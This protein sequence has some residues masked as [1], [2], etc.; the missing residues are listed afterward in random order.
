[1]S[2]CL[3]AIPAVLLCSLLMAAEKDVP[4]PKDLPAYGPNVPFTPPPV[5]QAKLENGLTLWLAP[6][7]TFPKATFELVVKGGYAADPQDR[8]GIA[9]L[10][11]SA[12]LEGTKTLS[13]K[14]IAEAIQDCGGDLNADA[15]A[16]AISIRT[17]VL[18][19]KAVAA[20]GLLSDIAQNAAFPE[21]EVAIVK[22]NAASQ[23]E[24]DEAEPGFLG[25]RALRRAIFGGHPYAVI[26]PTK[27]TIQQTTAAELKREFARRFRP[28]H[29]ILVA[30]GD[31][32]PKQLRAVIE[33]AFGVWR[34][35]GEGI[36]ATSPPVASITK[37]VVY[38]PRPN[39]VQTAF[40]IGALAPNLPAPEHEAAELAN[41]IYGGMFGSRLTR[42]IREDKGYT[43]SPYSYVSSFSTAGLLVTGADVRN[44]VTG[45]SF[46]EI[47]Y[48]LNRLA[49]TTPETEELERAKRFS[50]GSMTIFLQAQ[51]PLARTL[52]EYWV[53]GLTPADLSREGEKL[54][55]TSAAEVHAAAEKYFPMSRMTIV[56][57]GD[58]TVIRRQLAPFG[59]ELTKSQ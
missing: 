21:D 37:T 14:Q 19:E 52:A 32:D 1:M 11:A 27:E 47:S 33:K 43:Y 10:V 46:N 3:H 48:E 16:D 8:P 51:S 31:F 30:I 57:V 25:R 56:A 36:P 13:A 29:A 39:S 38:V 22:H 26:S 18:S 2:R 12:L 9:Q 15:T 23:L 5:A 49:T 24:S 42:N 28:D 45:P 59:V 35:A 4:L 58:E 50:I 54:D 55:H 53:D 40:Y 7:K 34:S 6:M 17:S 20:V 44:E 41:A